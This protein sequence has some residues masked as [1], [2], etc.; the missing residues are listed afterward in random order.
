M[1]NWFIFIL[2]CLVM[3]GVGFWS[4]RTVGENASDEDFLLGGEVMSVLLWEQ[5]LLLLVFL[6]GA[7]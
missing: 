3:I 4:S 7:L 5:L 2:T 1:F 6:A